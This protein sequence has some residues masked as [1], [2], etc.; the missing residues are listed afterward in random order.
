M[1][2]FDASWRVPAHACA[3]NFRGYR[4][5]FRNNIQLTEIR[6]RVTISLPFHLRYRAARK[7]SKWILLPPLPPAPLVSPAFFVETRIRSFVRFDPGR[8]GSSSLFIL[9]FPEFRKKNSF[10]ETVDRIARNY[11]SNRRRFIRMGRRG[12]GRKELCADTQREIIN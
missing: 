6:Y 3:A 9:G 5:A 11:T 4:R 10:F 2:P 8:E 12:G 1:K 7:E